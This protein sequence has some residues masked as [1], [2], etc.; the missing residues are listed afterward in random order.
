MESTTLILLA[1]RLWI[2][3]A[4][5]H[6]SHPK[7]D[8]FSKD[9]IRQVLRA[10]GLDEGMKEGSINA[11][12]KEHCVANVPPSSG[13]Y[14]MLYETEPGRLRLFKPGDLAHPARIQPRKPSKTTPRR[15][16]IPSKYWELLDWY[17][18]WSATG[19]PNG[20]RSV[21]RAYSDDPLLRLV[22]SGKHLWADEHADEYIERLR[23]EE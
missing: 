5:L 7:R 10:E 1:D 19:G 4:V 14:R 22:G 8:S 18:K 2:A 13:K 23:R 16:E 3:T 12:L 6:Q 21:S 17:Q 15:E 20:S 11:H 9:E